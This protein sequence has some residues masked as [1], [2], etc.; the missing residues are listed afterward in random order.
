MKYMIA[1]AVLCL[2]LAA[3]DAQGQITVFPGSYTLT[4]NAADGSLTLDTFGGD[5]YQYVIRGTGSDGVDDGFIEGNFNPI[6]FPVPVDVGS[7]TTTEDD[8]LSQATLNPWT[9]LG[10]QNL[11]NVLQ[12]GLSESE[13][14]AKINTDASDPQNVTYSH[15]A[16]ELGSQ[17]FFL[18]D[19]NYEVPEPGSIVLLGIGTALLA[20]R[21][22][23]RV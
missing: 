11:G 3:T 5:L 10:P 22:R 21:R 12:P 2:M 23:D 7:M 17:E 18:F 15:Y 8:E 19:I 14:N 1:P 16:I 6:A 9:G 4:Y 13:F 20:Q